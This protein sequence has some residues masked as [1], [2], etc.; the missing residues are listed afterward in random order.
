[1]ISTALPVPESTGAGRQPVI[2]TGLP[3]AEST[4]AGRGGRDERGVAGRSR[5]VPRGRPVRLPAVRG[6]MTVTA[7]TRPR[8]TVA[9]PTGR[10]EG[11]VTA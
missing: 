6:M 5:A 1:V 2:S 9:L 11:A 10:P 3:V 8:L 4:G 7:E